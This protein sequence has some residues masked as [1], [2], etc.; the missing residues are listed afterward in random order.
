[1]TWRRR[2]VG[3]WARPLLLGA[4]SV[5]MQDPTPDFR[6]DAGDDLA[7]AV[8]WAWARPL[9]LG[10]LSVVMQDPTPDFPKAERSP[11]AKRKASTQ[12]TAAGATCHSFQ[13]LLTELALVV[14]NTIEV[15]GTSVTF[16]KATEPD[17]TQARALELAGSTPKT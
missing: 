4:L 8:R 9:L 14:R 13:S 12:R 1:M 3:A 2:F 5:V 10:A 11:T 17:P 16:T 7:P 15:P 6:H